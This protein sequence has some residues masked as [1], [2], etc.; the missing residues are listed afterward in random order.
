MLKHLVG[1]VLK[2]I[3]EVEYDRRLYYSYKLNLTYE[4][5]FIFS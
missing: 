5:Q 1:F 4:I 3:L 2:K